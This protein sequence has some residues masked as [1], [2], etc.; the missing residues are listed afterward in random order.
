MRVLNESIRV[1][2]KIKVNSVTCDVEEEGDWRHGILLCEKRGWV[3]PSIPTSGRR[4]YFL[5]LKAVC[6]FDHRT[7]FSSDLS[8]PIFVIS[9]FSNMPDPVASATQSA[10]PLPSLSGTQTCKLTAPI[11]ASPT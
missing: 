5:S 8:S 9:S 6:T 11:G 2:E 4:G 10:L 7:Y 3:S 1:T